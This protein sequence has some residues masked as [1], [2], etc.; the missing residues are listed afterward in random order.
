MLMEIF[1]IKY[2]CSDL[3]SIHW[4]QEYIQKEFMTILGII[5]VKD[6]FCKNVA[7]SKGERKMFNKRKKLVHAELEQKAL[8]ALKEM[9]NAANVYCEGHAVDSTESDFDGDDDLKIYC[10]D[11]VLAT[12]RLYETYGT[13]EKVKRENALH[14]RKLLEICESYSEEEANIACAVF[15]RRFPNAMYN[16]LNNEHTNMVAMVTGVNQLNTSYIEKMCSI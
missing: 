2:E 7:N 5:G 12:E 4:S 6:S 15:A 1:W 10:R 16:A 9:T 3:I 14:K 13:S 8:N 11:D